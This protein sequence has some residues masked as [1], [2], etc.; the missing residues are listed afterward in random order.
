MAEHQLSL[1]LNLPP[2]QREPRRTCTGA[3]KTCQNKLH[4]DIKSCQQENANHDSD[5]V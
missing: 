1:P 3:C 2:Q 5:K 4:D